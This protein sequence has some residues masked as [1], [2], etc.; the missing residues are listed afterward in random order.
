MIIFTVL[1]VIVIILF[2]IK[3]NRDIVD[4]QKGLEKLRNNR[5]SIG[6]DEVF[7]K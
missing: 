6:Y 3:P 4:L 1:V 7:R 2:L 5:L